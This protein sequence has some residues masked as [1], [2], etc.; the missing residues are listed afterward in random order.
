MVSEIKVTTTSLKTSTTKFCFVGLDSRKIM[1]LKIWLLYN[2]TT[3]YPL[4]LAYFSKNTSNLII[5]CCAE[6]IIKAFLTLK[7][8]FDEVLENT[9]TLSTLNRNSRDDDVHCCVNQN[10]KNCKRVFHIKKMISKCFF[11]WKICH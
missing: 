5:Y 3:T 1:T 11:S 10:K 6:P 2:P 7:I 8:W 9:S 4:K